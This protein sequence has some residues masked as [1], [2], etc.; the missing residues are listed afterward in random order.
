M[1]HKL[2]G[3]DGVGDAFEVVTLS[4]GEIVHG[5]AVPLC[6]GAVVGCLYDAVHDG[7][8][9]VHVGVGHVEL[10]SQDHGSLHCLWRVHLAEET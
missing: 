10:G 8:T 4:M 5:V 7:V 6:A 2:Q 9:E 3:T 1:G